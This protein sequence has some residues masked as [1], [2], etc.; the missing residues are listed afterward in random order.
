VPGLFLSALKPDNTIGREKE[1]SYS[2]EALLWIACVPGCFLWAYFMNQSQK[3]NKSFNS[4]TIG[5]LISSGFYF[6]R[7][8]TNL[9]ALGYS[10][11]QPEPDTEWCH[12]NRVKLSLHCRDSSV[13]LWFVLGLLTEEPSLRRES[14][15]PRLMAESKQP[16]VL[17]T[18]AQKY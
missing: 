6:S 13:V 5:S 2:L 16:S 17:S 1:M 4:L 12:W 14:T 11:F 9:K 10:K 7:R 3:A 18:P 15:K 8:V